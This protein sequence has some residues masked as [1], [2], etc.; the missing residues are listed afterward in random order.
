MLL[1][2]RY[3]CMNGT[4]NIERRTVNNETKCTRLLKNVILI[5]PQ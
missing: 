4:V 2:V 1:Y 3:N 5:F